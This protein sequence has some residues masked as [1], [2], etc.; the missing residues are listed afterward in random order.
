MDLE[1]EFKEVNECRLIDEH[2][3]PS[4]SYP[5]SFTEDEKTARMSH[6]QWIYYNGFTFKP[7]QTV[8]HVSLDGMKLSIPCSYLAE[9]LIRLAKDSAFDPPPSEP[10]RH[11]YICENF[12]PECVP[13]F[14][15]IDGLVVLGREASL[16][17]L[18]EDICRV[19]QFS[20]SKFFPTEKEL[21]VLVAYTSP[22]ARHGRFIKFG[23]HIVFPKLLL[24][25]D[26]VLRI[27]ELAKFDLAH[28]FRGVKIFAGETQIHKMVDDG[29][30]KGGSLRQPTCYKMV[31]CS[32]CGGKRNQITKCQQC[33]G[34]GRIHVP[35]AYSPAFVLA[36][37]GKK[38]EIATA[39][40]KRSVV[41]SLYLSSL[42]KPADMQVRVHQGFKP[43]LDAPL[44]LALEKRKR[45]EE[46]AAAEEPADEETQE[47]DADGN[48][49]PVKKARV[50]KKKTEEDEKIEK[51]QKETGTSAQRIR[52][53]KESVAV[54]VLEKVIQSYVPE[55][56]RLQISSVQI[57]PKR[58][59]PAVVFV[60]GVGQHHCPNKGTVHSRSSTWFRVQ[61]NMVEHLCTSK[62]PDTRKDG[63]QCSN[64]RHV[65][66]AL[67]EVLIRAL[68]YKHP[69]R[70]KMQ[71]DVFIYE[72]DKI[73][74]DAAWQTSEMKRLSPA[75][76]AAGDMMRNLIALRSNTGDRLKS[77]MKDSLASKASFVYKALFL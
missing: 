34:R 3:F 5:R 60:E 18:I 52:L 44:P 13:L 39:Q 8:S 59:F 65:L 49:P 77:L 62:K 6:R 33:E 4:T 7:E 27:F 36:E 50:S 55:Y 11:N 75:D 40:I 68:F 76:G 47:C 51:R 30:Y 21:P 54:A 46:E 66:P 16:D 15:D 61:E 69:G 58:S 9:H 37:D 57:G 22:P 64:W 25:I 73:L 31:K 2:C 43:P 26:Q 17:K 48:P 12:K 38:D 20:A 28:A 56:S 24:A 45:E 1:K 10:R 72:S 29:P 70:T 23:A 67:P 74:L 71:D 53:P 41:L 35:R 42:R 19:I 32:Q 14:V 63:V